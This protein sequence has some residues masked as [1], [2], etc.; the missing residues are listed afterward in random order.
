MDRLRCRPHGRTPNHVVHDGAEVD[1]SEFIELEISDWDAPG[2]WVETDCPGNAAYGTL[3]FS[4]QAVAALGDLLTPCGYFLNTVLPTGTRYKIYI[5]EREIK[6]LDEE[7][8]VIERFESTRRIQEVMRFELYAEALATSDVCRLRGLRS[9]VFVSDEFVRLVETH[10]LTGFLFT[11]IWP[12]ETGGTGLRVNRGA[13]KP[14]AKRAALRA[15]L[16]A[17]ADAQQ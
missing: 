4:E 10:R 13:I 5:C 17:R 7:R 12:G 8:S 1:R 6:A 16:T 9:D 14:P 2:D 11:Q 15:E 3:L